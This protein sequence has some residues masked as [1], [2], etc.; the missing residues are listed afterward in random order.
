MKN[1]AEMSPIALKKKRFPAQFIPNAAKRLEENGV[2]VVYPSE[3]D[4]KKMEAIAADF[5][6]SW[7]NDYTDSVKE[8][9]KAIKSALNK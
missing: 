1:W 9:Y 8:C 2:T 3:E 4:I 5:W 7:S 6:E